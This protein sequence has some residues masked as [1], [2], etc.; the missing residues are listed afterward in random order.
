M[1]TDNE[2]LRPKLRELNETVVKMCYHIYNRRLTCTQLLVQYN[3]WGIN[4]RELMESSS[5]HEQIEQCHNTQ[6]SF[7]IQYLSTKLN[8]QEQ[9]NH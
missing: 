7:F 4:S 2:V 3:E 5:Y 1:I 8:Q 6:D 9:I